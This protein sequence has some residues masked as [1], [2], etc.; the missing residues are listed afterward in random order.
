MFVD[1]CVREMVCVYS[2][3]VS[4]CERGHSP[5]T[6]SGCV[7]N[8]EERC[9]QSRRDLGETLFYGVKNGPVLCQRLR[10]CYKKKKCKTANLS[11]RSSY[12]VFKIKLGNV[13]N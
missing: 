3:C 10:E 12:P 8:E 5:V 11:G 4:A 6:R 13:I 1:V 2:V 7:M 9:L